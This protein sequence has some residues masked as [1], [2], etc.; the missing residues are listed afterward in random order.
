MKQG[1]NP[2]HKIQRIF[3]LTLF[4]VLAFMIGSVIILS[5]VPPVSR[6]AL[7]HHLAVPK[8]WIQNGGFCEIPHNIFSYYP[9]NLDLLY[10]IPLYFGNDSVPK[11]IHFSFSLLTAYLIFSYLKQKT[12]LLYGLMGVVLFL[13]LPIIIKLSI[14]VYVDLG[15][16][17]FSFASLILVLKWKDAGF[18]PGTLVMAAVCCGFA[19]GTKYNGMISFFLL[20]CLV[21]VIYLRSNRSKPE[22]SKI[23]KKGSASQLRAGG[24]GIVFMAVALVVFSPWLVKNYM[25]T[26][27][28]V[29]P[30]FDEYFRSH[31]KSVE[32]LP[33]DGNTPIESIPEK[34]HVLSNHFILRKLIYGE[35]PLQTALI[36][37]RIFFEGKDDSPKYFDGRLNPFLL[38]LPMFLFLRR[39]RISRD[40]KE[41]ILIIAAFSAFYI[42]F[43][44]FYQDMRIRWI[45]PA[46][47]GLVILSIL[48]LKNLVGYLQY[49]W[50]KGFDQFGTIV[51]AFLFFLVLT[52]NL[53]YLVLQ[54]GVVRPIAYLSGKIDRAQYIAQY[55]KDFPVTQH[56]N[57]HLPEDAVILGIFMGNR[58]YYI[59]NKIV[60]NDNLLYDLLKQTDD[61][62]QIAKKLKSEGVTHLLIWNELFSKQTTERLNQMQSD[63]MEKFF[64]QFTLKLYSKN[65]YSLYACKNI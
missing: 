56:A 12:E 28:P 2:N 47:P 49:K 17:Y 34:K 55:R 4:T 63:E 65:G 58:S 62:F 21:P 10:I 8:I 19:L 6:D 38:I 33:D 11:L 25:L 5:L 53:H 51:T 24:Y 29:Y 50:F 27:N 7:T 40:I 36:P 41:E 23:G 26:D 22:K 16:I 60:F 32:L 59:D 42:L 18:P 31:E 15:L 43:V 3:N 61:H 13:S 1:P 52:I 44:Y 14:T 45:G 48:G 37:I 57:K 64:Q 9:M 46:I 20:T 39:K 35:T 54:F 30:L